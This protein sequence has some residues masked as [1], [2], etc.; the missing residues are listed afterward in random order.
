[1]LITCLG[2]VLPTYR[3]ELRDA[4]RGSGIQ[5]HPWPHRKSEL[6]L[7]YKRLS[8]KHIM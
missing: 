3:L 1:M 6:T 8:L 7:G 4:D 2:V 5:G